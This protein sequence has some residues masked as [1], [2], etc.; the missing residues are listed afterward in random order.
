[1][2]RLTALLKTSLLIASLGHLTLGQAQNNPSTTAASC[3]A[4]AEVTAL[5]LY[6]AWQA[7]WD[8]LDEPATLTLGRNPEHTD[9]LRGSLRRGTAEA[10][11]AGD[12][13]D[14][15]FTL[16]ESTDGRT[17][18]ATWTG[19]VTENACGK[20]IQGLWTRASDNSERRFVLRRLPGWQ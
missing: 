8:G 9:G 12:V 10:L 17:I 19:K 15:D 16:E 20:E 5:H 14:G 4:P 2:S 7:R 18:A 3:P 6:G 11:V 1:M 13:D